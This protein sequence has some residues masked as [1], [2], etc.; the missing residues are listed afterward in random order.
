MPEPDLKYMVERVSFIES[1]FHEAF[2]LYCFLSE[3]DKVTDQEYKRLSDL[4]N[5]VDTAI[6]D[7][8]LYLDGV[9]IPREDSYL[10]CLLDKGNM[11]DQLDDIVYFLDE[12][13]R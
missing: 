6:K 12:I 3:Q 2:S 7:Y 10:T 4:Y 13:K 5:L 1:S 9:A 11:G 8:Y